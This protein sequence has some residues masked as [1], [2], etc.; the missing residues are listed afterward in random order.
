MFTPVQILGL[1]YLAIMALDFLL[2]LW[3]DPK[4]QKRV[5]S[6]KSLVR[7]GKEKARSETKY[8]YLCRFQEN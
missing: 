3:T 6:I 8:I 1:T 4:I 5:L 7:L 2:L